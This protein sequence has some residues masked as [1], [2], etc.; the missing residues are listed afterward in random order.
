MKK[1]QVLKHLPQL[2]DYRKDLK[3]KTALSDKLEREI[4]EIET[5]LTE[6]DGVTIHN[7]FPVAVDDHADPD[8]VEIWSG[9]DESKRYAYVSRDS[10]AGTTPERWRATGYKE[11]GDGNGRMLVEGVSR[12]AAVRAGKDFVATGKVTKAE[13]RAKVARGPK[14][15]GATA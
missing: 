10:V 14:Q 12:A 5:V 7:D 4:E 2:K 8:A 1:L 11:E 6:L 15:D 13:P 3:A 9:C